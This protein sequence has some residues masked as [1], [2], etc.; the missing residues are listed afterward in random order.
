[1]PYAGAVVP[2]NGK[3]FERDL[4]DQYKFNQ[5]QPPMDYMGNDKSSIL[6][7]MM[8]YRDYPGAGGAYDRYGG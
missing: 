2:F 5:Q 3:T 1:M 4:I 6:R 7:R 8:M